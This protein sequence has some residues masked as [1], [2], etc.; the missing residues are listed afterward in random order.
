MLEYG[1]I[2]DAIYENYHLGENTTMESL[3]RFL[4]TIRE[5]FQ[6]VC[7]KQPTQEDLEC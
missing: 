6:H 2:A 3:K 7:L 5:L 1:I 4:Q